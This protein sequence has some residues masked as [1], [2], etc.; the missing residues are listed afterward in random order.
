MNKILVMNV[1]WMG[2]VI[3][4]APIFRNLKNTY[5]HASIY[6]LAVPRVREVLE[7]IP[8]IEHIIIYDEY[9]LHRSPIAKIKL[10]HKLKIECFDCVF[11]L[12]RSLTRALISKLNFCIISSLISFFLL[13]ISITS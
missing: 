6:C 11:I 12:H 3:F 10:I 9:G 8:E 13:V 1:N 5:K 2:D 4:S 7:M